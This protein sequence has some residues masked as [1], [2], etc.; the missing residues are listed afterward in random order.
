[1]PATVHRQPDTFHGFFSLPGPLFAPAG[2]A[3]QLA[4]TALRDALA[5]TD[6]RSAR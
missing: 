5:A 4:A 2:E 3:Q 6:D 1:M